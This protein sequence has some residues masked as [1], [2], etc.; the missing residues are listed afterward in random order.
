MAGSFPIAKIW[1]H[2]NGPS[3]DEWIKKN[4]ECIHKHTH[5]HTQT[6]TW[7]ISHK[8]NEILTFVTTWMNLESIILS[9]KVRERQIVYG[10]IYK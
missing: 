4:V 5:T 1:K 7:N 6:H 8:K 9:E 2:L 10:F 3:I